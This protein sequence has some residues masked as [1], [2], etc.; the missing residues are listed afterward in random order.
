MT[1]IANCEL[2][3]KINLDIQRLEIELAEAKAA[4]SYISRTMNRSPR[5][6]APK[7]SS[8]KPAKSSMPLSAD[9]TQVDLS[10]PLSELTQYEAA[11]TVL[12]NA[13]KSLKTGEIADAM[14]AGGFPQTD[15]K[16]L[17]ISLFTSMT[18]KSEIF[19][20]AGSGSWKLA[21]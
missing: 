9:S 17:S 5:K 10:K 11:A 20:K 6:Q 3:E 13:G 8:K 4:A 14:I 16:K 7:K 12:K 21:Q 19:K 2:L 18:R 1:T 15:R